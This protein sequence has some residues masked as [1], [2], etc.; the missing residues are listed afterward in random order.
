[1][2]VNA[3]STAFKAKSRLTYAKLKPYLDGNVPFAKDMLLDM[4]PRSFHFTQ[5]KDYV[6]PFSKDEAGLKSKE[7]LIDFYA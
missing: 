1:M 5:I 7:Q 3:R 6:G 2:S 4:S